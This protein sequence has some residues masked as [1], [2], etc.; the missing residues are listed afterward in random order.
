M[1]GTAL[2]LGMHSVGEH[3]HLIRWQEFINASYLSIDTCCS[4][5]SACVESV[6]GFLYPNP[7]RRV[8]VAAP[9]LL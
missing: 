1:S 2:I 7:R 9:E 5:P 4:F 3:D 8:G 6:M